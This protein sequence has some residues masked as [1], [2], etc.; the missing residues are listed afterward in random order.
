MRSVGQIKSG[1]K[2]ERER[3]KSLRESRRRRNIPFYNKAPGIIKTRLNLWA[4]AV[5]R[6]AGS[7]VVVP[8]FAHK[9][10]YILLLG[11]QKSASIKIKSAAITGART[12]SFFIFVFIEI[13]DCDKEGWTSVCVCVCRVRALAGYRPGRTKLLAAQSRDDAN[14]VCREREIYKLPARIVYYIY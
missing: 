5:V 4:L 14:A 8:H 3:D 6:C 7:R 12:A 2:T 1:S 11:T 9:N 10:I 13:S